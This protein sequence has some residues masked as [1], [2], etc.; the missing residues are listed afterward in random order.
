M[1]ER[2]MEDLIA[3]NP[4]HFFPGH[5]F[6]AKVAKPAKEFLAAFA[7]FARNTSSTKLLIGPLWIVGPPPPPVSSPPV[8]PRGR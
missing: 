3:A 5:G 4:E 2:E 6:L 7:G 8:S 1:L